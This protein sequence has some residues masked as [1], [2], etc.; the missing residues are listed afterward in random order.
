MIGDALDRCCRS[1]EAGAGRAHAE[2][3]A[4]RE[5]GAQPTFL[6]VFATSQSTF[7]WA[8]KSFSNVLK[9]AGTLPHHVAVTEH[10]MPVGRRCAEH[11]SVPVGVL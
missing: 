7:D 3:F 10:D 1:Y 4:F 2:Q 9:H 8:S 11:L 6:R 5:D